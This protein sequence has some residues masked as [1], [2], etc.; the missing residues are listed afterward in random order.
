[1]SGSKGW[2]VQEERMQLL[3]AFLREQEQLEEFDFRMNFLASDCLES[4]LTTIAQTP[5][6]CN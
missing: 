3:C 6:L 1:M 4:L 5:K 2:W